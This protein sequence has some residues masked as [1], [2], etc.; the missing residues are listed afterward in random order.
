MKKANY[1]MIILKEFVKTDF[2]LRYQGS[3]LGYLWSVLKP[4]AMFC[5][6]YVILVNF[7]RVKGDIP[8]YGLYLLLGII[9]WNM[10]AEITSS[11]IG[12]VVAKGD[13]IRKV[14]FP[15]TVI[16]VSSTLSAMINV[17]INLSIVAIF[18]IFLSV[19]LTWYLPTFFLFMIE[20][21]A[22]AMGISFFLSATY[23]KYR[24]INHIWDVIMQA[25]FYFTPILY[26][27]YQYVPASI[28][29]IM[30]ASP[31]TQSIQGARYALI[32]HDHVITAYNT[33][34]PVLLTIVPALIAVAT[35]VLG[36]RYYMKKSAYFA[37]NV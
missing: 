29:T 28:A 36:Y 27:L 24:D 18:M 26:P 12:A 2:K 5:I 25:A 35:L 9:L 21:A 19:P 17:I 34:Y 11:S 32:P 6:L 13:L 10:F 4:L 22:F 7:M 37:E 31:V 1:S 33:S 15:K 3:V 8:Y 20:M 16:I 14:N 23:V 30:L